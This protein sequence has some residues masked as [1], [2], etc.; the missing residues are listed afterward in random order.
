MLRALSVAWALLAVLATGFVPSAGPHAHASE[1]ATMGAAGVSGAGPTVSVR[2][3]RAKVTH[4][5]AQT[6]GHHPVAWP[7]VLWLLSTARSFVPELVKGGVALAAPA[8]PATATRGTAR[9]S[10]GPP[11][12][13]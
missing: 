10:R 7:H 4:Q 3:L 8:L 1:V 2:R 6:D 5:E 9:T 12:S 13:A 11:P